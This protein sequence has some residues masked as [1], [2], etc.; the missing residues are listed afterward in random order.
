MEIKE[1]QKSALAFLTESDR[2]TAVVGSCSK[3]GNCHVAT[4]YYFVDDNFN[5]YFL[6]ATHSQKYTNLMENPNAALAVGFGPSQTTI[7]G[8][9]TAVLLEKS[10]EA[11][12]EAIAHIKQ[13]LQNHENETWPIFQLDTYDSQAI[14][15]FQ[16]IP[17][18]LQ[19]LN[20]EHDGG[21]EITSEG[22]MQI[23]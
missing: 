17:D 21:L 10:S 13:R 6:T 8:Q 9:G 2:L 23:I 11:E 20:L 15:V 3:D 1:I 18:T 7:Q 12:K 19:L 4:V 14:A 16:F 22:V 5:F